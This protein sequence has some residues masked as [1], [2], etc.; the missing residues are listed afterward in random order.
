LK[1]TLKTLA[2]KCGCSVTSVSR[3]LKNSDTISKE[4]R[5]KVQNTAKELGYVPN[6]LAGS[7]RKGYTKTLAIILQDL[8]NP[9]YSLLAKYVEAYA[10][11]LGYTLI[12]M[13]TSENPDR[14]YECVINAMQKGVDGILYLPIQHD[15]RCIDILKKNNF[16]FVLVGRIFEGI[17]S[18]YVI[19]NDKKSAYIATEYLLK[20]GHKRI[21]FLNTFLNI[22][23][24]QERFYGYKDALKYYGHNIND[25]DMLNI[26]MEM[27]ETKKTIE[28]LFKDGLKDYTAIL[29]FCDMMAFEAV[30]SLRKLGYK[31][32][33]D[34]AVASI[35]DI[36]SEI[37]MPIK[38]TSVTFPR[39]ETAKCAVDILISNI[40]NKDNG[41]ERKYTKK[42]LDVSLNIGETT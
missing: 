20:K 24:A 27:G 14:E 26:S 19:P 28:N 9:Y 13:T 25:S 4:L 31:I 8:R 12:I 18:N 21:L 38:L 29:C 15:D 23:S 3:A 10:S 7:M 41:F 40:K 2:E 39:Q 35:D 37:I 22:Y 42:I 5:I 33:N 36:H 11:F 30:Y 16:P 32:P 34:I 6:T 1:V 17:D